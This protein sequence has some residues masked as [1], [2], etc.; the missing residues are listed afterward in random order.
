[1]R[2]FH[3]VVCDTFAASGVDLFDRFE[4]HY[5]HTRT[6]VKVPVINL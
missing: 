6:W 4:S 1:M 3:V 5:D 2:T